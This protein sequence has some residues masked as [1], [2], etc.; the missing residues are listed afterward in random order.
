MS[1]TSL[2]IAILLLFLV[3][4][5]AYIV[6]TKFMPEPL[7]TPVLAIVGVILL[8]VILGYATG[9]ISLGGRA[10]MLK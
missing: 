4:Y 6:I 2:L 1:V 8:I 3:G 10:L 5:G 7:R 9:E